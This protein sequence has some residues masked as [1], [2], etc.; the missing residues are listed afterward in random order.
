MRTYENLRVHLTQRNKAQHVVV[1]MHLTRHL[2]FHKAVEHLIQVR[3]NKDLASAGWHNGAQ[4]L[5]IAQLKGSSL[6]SA[7]CLTSRRA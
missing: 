4:I 7:L 6:Q 3:A 1:K 5:A 2:Q